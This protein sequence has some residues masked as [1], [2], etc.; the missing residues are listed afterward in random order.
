V[1]EVTTSLE[2]DGAGFACTGLVDGRDDPGHRRFDGSPV[3]VI[4]ERR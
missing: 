4:E 2:V 1:E 3:V